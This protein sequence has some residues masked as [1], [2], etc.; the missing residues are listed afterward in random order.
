MAHKS[1][2]GSATIAE[3]FFM[4]QLALRI[5]ASYHRTRFAEPET[6]LPEQSL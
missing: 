1:M 5:R 3:S 4:R 6:K 2:V